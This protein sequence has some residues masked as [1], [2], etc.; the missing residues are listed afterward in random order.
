MEWL[1]CFSFSSYFLLFLIKAKRTYNI[2][3]WKWKKERKKWMSLSISFFPYSIFFSH[4]GVFVF[5]V[6]VNCEF[7]SL[8]VGKKRKKKFILST[9]NSSA[10]LCTEWEWKIFVYFFL[11]FIH[12]HRITIIFSSFSSPIYSLHVSWRRK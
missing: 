9:I 11:F 1:F 10:W 2:V 4:L 8:F 12:N 5:H 6:A 7:F 3:N